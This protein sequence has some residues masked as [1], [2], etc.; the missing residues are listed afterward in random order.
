MLAATWIWLKGSN[1]VL[2]NGPVNVAPAA[3]ALPGGSFAL[4][5]H[6]GRSVTDQDFR[7]RFVL[8]VFGYTFCP[9]VCPTTLL[10]VANALELLGERA[11]MVQPLFVTIDPERD[12]AEVLAAYVGAFDPRIIGLTGTQQQLDQVTDNYRVYY[13][14]AGDGDDYFM[15]HSAFIYLI[16]PRGRPLTY[17]RHDASAEE[18]AAVIGALLDETAQIR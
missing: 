8:L 17:L 15:D 7:G 5:D 14:K 9:D 12:S 3:A 6:T 13:A 1:P 11:A 2:I 18:M 16:D 10:R 4:Q